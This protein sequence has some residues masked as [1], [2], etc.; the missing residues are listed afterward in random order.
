MHAPTQ[1]Q[2]SILIPFDSPTMAD[3]CRKSHV[4][5]MSYNNIIIA[6]QHSFLPYNYLEFLS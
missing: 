5:I 6:Q 2:S 3:P 1:Q 4:G